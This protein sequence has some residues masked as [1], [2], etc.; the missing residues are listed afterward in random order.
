MEQCCKTCY[1]Y[2]SKGQRVGLCHCDDF[3]SARVLGGVFTR[4]KNCCVNW[5]AME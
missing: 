2:E 5:R 1:W 3:Q 4:A